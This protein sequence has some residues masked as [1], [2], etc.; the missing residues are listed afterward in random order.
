[1]LPKRERI[2][3]GSEI[4]AIIREKQFEGK[5]PLLYFVGRENGL[6]FSRATIVTPGKLG[7]AVIRNR[8]KRVFSEAYRK[9][10][11]NIAKNID[12]VIYPRRSA[13]GAGLKTVLSG[14]D[15]C[16]AALG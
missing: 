1:M 9:K 4:K 10:R 6:G 14:L 3:R 12:F 15:K 7:N 16:L 11:H 13:I 5:A 8:L 2:A